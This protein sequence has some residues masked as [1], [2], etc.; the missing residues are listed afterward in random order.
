MVQRFLETTLFRRW[1]QPPH[2]HPDSFAVPLWSGIACTN[3]GLQG[4]LIPYK[5]IRGRGDSPACLL[6]YT[7]QVIPHD[8]IYWE[9][10]GIGPHQFL[11]GTTTKT[12]GTASYIDLIFNMVTKTIP[13][14]RSYES[15]WW[16]YL[17]LYIIMM[18]NLHRLVDTYLKPWWTIPYWPSWFG[19]LVP[20]C[21]SLGSIYSRV[22]ILEPF[23]NPH[24]GFSE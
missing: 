5:V 15:E 20:T 3:W 8:D 17:S 21:P 16:N 14:E 11:Q 23:Y 7:T 9:R 18:H 22:L 19:M 6:P 13:E 4:P 24:M 1:Y 10:R 12:E 2:S